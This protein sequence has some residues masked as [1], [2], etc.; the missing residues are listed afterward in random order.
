MTYTTGL[1]NNTRRAAQ[2]R[3]PHG[4]RRGRAADLRVALELRSR[5]SSEHIE[6]LSGFAH[7]ALNGAA[8][9]RFATD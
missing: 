9:P 1:T 7:A 8:Q 6:T 4:G 3:E 5:L 2:A